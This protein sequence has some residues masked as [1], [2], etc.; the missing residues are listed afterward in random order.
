MKNGLLCQDMQC[1]NAKKQVKISPVLGAKTGE[2]FTCFL[3]HISRFLHQFWWIFAPLGGGKWGEEKW[4]SE[5]PHGA[6]RK[7][8]KGTVF[9]A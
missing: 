5:T 4:S 8:K 7:V 9:E 1:K 3:H 2:N 6:K